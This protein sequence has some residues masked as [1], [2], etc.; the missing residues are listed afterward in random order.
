MG[1]LQNNYAQ[2]VPGALISASYVSDLYDVLTGNEPEDVTISG[3]FIVSGSAISTVGFTGSLQGTASFSISSSYALSSSY[4][5][6]ASYAPFSDSASVSTTSV[7]SSYA[8]LA[9]TALTASYVLF[10]DSSSAADTSISASY[11]LSASYAPPTLWSDIYTNST[12]N[13]IYV[14]PSGSDSNDGLSSTKP[15]QTLY[16]A[17]VS[18]SAGSVIVIG[19]GEYVYDNR[20]SEGNP[21]NDRQDEINLWKDQV[22]YYAEPGSKIIIKTENASQT[23]DLFNPGTGSNETCT[24]DGYLEFEN[25]GFGPDTGGIGTFIGSINDNGYTFNANVKRLY[26]DHNQIINIIKSNTAGTTASISINSD[27]EV[28]LYSGGNVS[29]GSFYY[30]QGS[31]TDSLVNINISSKKR[32]YNFGRTGYAYYIRTTFAIGSKINISGGECYNLTT[33]LFR[34]REAVNPELNV[35]IDTIYYDYNILTYSNGIITETFSGGS[36]IQDFTLNINAD[37]I[38]YSENSYSSQQLFAITGPNMKINFKGDIYTKTIG[39]T[40]RSIVYCG[41]YPFGNGT[42]RDNQINIDGN[43]YL[44]GSAETT[45]TLF[46]S[47]GANNVINFRGNIYGNFQTLAHPKAGGIVNINNAKVESTANTGRV[48][49]HTDNTTSTMRISNSDIT[50]LNTGSALSDGRYLNV[51]INNSAIKNSGTT[52]VLYNSTSNGS[53]QILN[54]SVYTSGGSAIN[55]TSPFNAAQTVINTAYSGS[56]TGSLTQ[57]TEMFI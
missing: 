46:E 2:I 40:G 28:W 56:L 36:N 50:M 6:S 12:G 39:G 45:S 15:L 49:I 55:Y 5:V 9:Q 35:N 1:V 20:N 22:T 32:D 16:T 41:L 23:L 19:A 31:G 37:L 11:A 57:L 30:I 21:W 48:Y 52:D 47:Y 34:F 44:L 42:A 38:D 3:S 4:A 8:T 53:L 43:I 27:E 26:S 13:I 10:I 29:A 54:S 17:K 7:S 25:L 24:I 18:A 14:S 33:P 51:L